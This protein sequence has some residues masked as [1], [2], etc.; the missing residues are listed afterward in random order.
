MLLH[1]RAFRGSPWLGFRACPGF[2]AP[3]LVMSK[4]R[5]L[6]VFRGDGRGAVGRK[7]PLGMGDLEGQ[8]LCRLIVLLVDG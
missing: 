3:T 5:F 1:G 8:S 4:I 2:G 6:G 7:N